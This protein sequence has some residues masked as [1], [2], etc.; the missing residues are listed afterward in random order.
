MGVT[1]PICPLASKQEIPFLVVW[2][3]HTPCTK[4]ETCYIESLEAIYLPRQRRPA[5]QKF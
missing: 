4:G 2:Q 1:M 5:W 3:R